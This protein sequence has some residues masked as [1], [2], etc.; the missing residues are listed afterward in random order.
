MIFVIFLI[1]I[2]LSSLETEKFILTKDGCSIST[3]INISTTSKIIVFEIHGLG[4]DKK[5]W[6]LLNTYLEKEKLSYISLDLRGHGNSIKCSY[7]KVKYPNLSLYDL[8]S[9]T[10]DL[11]SVYK[12]IKQNYP[13]LKIIPIGASIGANLA[14]TYFFNKSEKIILLSAGLKYTIYEIKNIFE[15]TKSK[16]FFIVSKQDTYSFESTKIFIDIILKRKTTFD[17]ITAEKG[18][19]VE[20]FNEPNDGINYISRL[21]YW[22]KN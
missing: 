7:G 16:I 15:K 8:K 11:D 1:N 9:F 6:N 5:E 19:G 18:H 20:I 12:H 3:I 21:I 17:I 2:Y 22:I 10:N 4:S 14:M 13:N